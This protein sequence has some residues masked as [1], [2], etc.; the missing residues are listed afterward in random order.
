[1][2]RPDVLIRFELDGKTWTYTGR[3]NRTELHEAKWWNARMDGV[4]K[5]WF[6]SYQTD[7]DQKRTD[8]LLNVTADEYLRRLITQA[9][10][11][12]VEVRSNR[13]D[14]AVRWIDLPDYY[15]R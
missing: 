1:M 8:D 7:E 2:K 9:G 12:I 3:P 5:E 10:G 13:P 15:V 14:G 6:G 4:I 11:R